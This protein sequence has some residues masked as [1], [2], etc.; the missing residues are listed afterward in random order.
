MGLFSFLKPSLHIDTKAIEQSIAELERHTSAELR[1]VVEFKAKNADSA[2]NRANELFA[3]LN[4]HETEQRNGV[5]IYLAFKPHLLAVV[6]DEGIH[7][8]VGEAFWQAVYAAMRHHCKQ[9]EF[10][11]AIQ[12]G[13]L[14]VQQA[15][16]EHF[17]IQEGDRNEL[18]NEVVIR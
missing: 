4:M 7:Q 17:P 5:L 6:G 10:T 11:Q 13:V 2:M 14:Q 1:V 16:A 18:S 8:K 9:G 15:L 12:A 3:E